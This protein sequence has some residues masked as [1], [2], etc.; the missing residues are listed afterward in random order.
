MPHFQGQLTVPSESFGWMEKRHELFR[1]QFVAAQ[2]KAAE[3]HLAE[4]QG[5]AP[6]ADVRP[7]E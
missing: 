3:A 1:S 7:E 5:Q 6:S 2:Q 4:K